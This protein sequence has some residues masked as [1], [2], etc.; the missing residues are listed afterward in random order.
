[1][2]IIDIALKYCYESPA[3]FARAFRD[4]HG[5]T[6]TDARKG[7]FAKA[8]PPISFA[9]TIKGVSEMEFR[10]EQMESF[11]MAGVVQLV[12]NKEP[13]NSPSVHN[14]VFAGAVTLAGA[15]ETKINRAHPGWA[16]IT[17]FDFEP[18][19]GKTKLAMGVS[20]F[21]TRDEDNITIP[22]AK[23][24]IFP[25]DTAQNAKEQCNET[26]ARILTEWLPSSGF[27]RDKSIAHMEVF[28]V[29]TPTRLAEI[30][31]PIIPK[32]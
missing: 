12:E 16:F 23:W 5:I 30:W 17:A 6:P 24:A 22:A 18:H 3:T 25:Y 29:G 4:M 27:S 32:S 2:K 13:D 1:E 20:N 19:E 31:M 7:A 15:P 26:Y 10:I 28:H 14:V 8:Y 21:D 11:T 9:L